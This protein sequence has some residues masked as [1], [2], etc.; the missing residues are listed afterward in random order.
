MQKSTALKCAVCRS[1]DQQ[2]D[3]IRA[4]DLDTRV[5]ELTAENQH[6]QGEVDEPLARVKDLTEQRGPGQPDGLGAGSGCQTD[7]PLDPLRQR[8]PRCRT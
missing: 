4:A 2:L 5:D 1:L 6:L 8:N 7:V 3:Q